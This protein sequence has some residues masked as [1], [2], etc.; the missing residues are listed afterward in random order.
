M[1]KLFAVLLILS[2]LVCTIYATGND[3]PNIIDNAD[4][5]TDAEEAALS[6]VA[7]QI[8]NTFSMDVVIVTV[9]SLEGKTA[10]AYA[11]DYFDYNGYGIG[12]QR[13]GILLLLSMEYRDWAISTSGECIRIF[14]DRDLDNIFGR[15]AGD[16]SND[17]YYSAFSRYLKLLN[18][19]FK[20]YENGSTVGTGDI[21]KRI[22]IALAIGAIA[23]G[24]TLAVMR[25]NMN[26]AKRQ[27]G[28]AN[29][30]VKNSFHLFKQQD[31]FLYSNT[32]RTRKQESSSSGG[33]SHRS[34]SGRSHGGRSGKF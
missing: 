10:E 4:L 14:R 28:A 29:Y 27:T 20:A 12:S 33:S 1:K 26:T 30:I 18:D 8:T 6:G 34:S 21:V 13:S 31:L 25:S 15:I 7:E 3:E 11:D 19:H 5:L 24:I 23:G 2:L 9:Y 32:T 22:L 16:L 17:N